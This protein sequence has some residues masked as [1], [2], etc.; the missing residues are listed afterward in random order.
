LRQPSGQPG[1]AI[2]YAVL[3][4]RMP[5]PT[6]VQTA[7]GGFGTLIL[8]WVLVHGEADK[9]AP[10]RTGSE[11]YQKQSFCETLEEDLLRG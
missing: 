4:K 10:C 11:E 3:K 1:N 6:A 7:V 5:G 9:S 2:K 8:V